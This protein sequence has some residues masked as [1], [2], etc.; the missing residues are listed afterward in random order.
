MR[1][2]YLAGNDFG[3]LIGVCLILFVIGV[4]GALAMV[5]TPEKFNLRVNR[6]DT[7][8]YSAL[9]ASVGFCG[10]FVISIHSFTMDELEAGRHWKNDCKLLEVNIPTGT[11]TDSVNKLDCAG[12]IINVPVSQYDEYI[13]QWELYK[14][15]N[16]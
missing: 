3:W 5:A 2:S 9:I 8:I 11:F 4:V 1:G 14:A 10:M 13:S 12:I 16:K 15:K 7:F 6:G